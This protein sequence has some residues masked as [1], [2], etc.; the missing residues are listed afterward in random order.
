[1]LVSH[2]SDDEDTTTTATDGEAAT[3]ERTAADEGAVADEGSAK[4]MDEECHGEA[5]YA[6]SSHTHTIEIT[7]H[8]RQEILLTDEQLDILQRG[9]AEFQAADAEGW[10]Q[11]IQD[12]VECIMR[13]LRQG[14]EFDREII[15]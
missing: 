2:T 3:N 12:C 14:A 8:F 1:M 9:V 15:Q 11:I 4:D 5:R 10:L 13:S 6:C 7:A